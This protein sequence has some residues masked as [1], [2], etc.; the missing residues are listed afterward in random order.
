M[1]TQT[2]IGT[3]AELA[4][5]DRKIQKEIKKS[6]KARNAMKKAERKMKKAA[7]ANDTAQVVELLGMAQVAVRK[8]RNIAA[9]NI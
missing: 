3:I 7:R 6:K 2:F 8:A 4:K 1:K 5:R 9:R